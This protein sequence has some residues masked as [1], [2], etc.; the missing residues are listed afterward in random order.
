MEFDDLIRSRFSVRSFKS[1]EISDEFKRVIVEAGILAPTAKN[2]QPEIIYV[3]ESKE[4]LDLIDSVTPCRYNAPVCMIVCSDMNKV[5]KNGD[6]NTAY[7][8]ASIVA[9]HMILE[10]KNLDIDSCW[11][12]SFDPKVLKEKFE[13]EDN[14][15]P[16]CILDFGYRTDNCKPSPMHSSRKSYFDVARMM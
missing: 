13:I 1:D 8:D 14:L 2:N 12:Q 6:F 5:Y 10:A 9:T 4:G 16:I 7:I 11:I 15:E 3:V